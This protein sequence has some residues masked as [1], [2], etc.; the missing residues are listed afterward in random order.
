M[1]WLSIGI[2]EV[3]CDLIL[4]NNIIIHLKYLWVIAGRHMEVANLRWLH[5]RVLATLGW[6]WRTIRVLLGWRSVSSSGCSVNDSIWVIWLLSFRCCPFKEISKF[7]KL[8]WWTTFITIHVVN[9]ACYL[10]SLII[11]LRFWGRYI[12]HGC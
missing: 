5:A 4:E 6:W 10:R 12:H 3:T 8:D 9:N 2:H 1:F 7:Q 11:V